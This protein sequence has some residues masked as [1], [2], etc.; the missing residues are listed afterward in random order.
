MLRISVARKRRPT[1]PLNPFYGYP[2]ELIAEWCGVSVGTAEH[3]KAGRRKPS[4]PVLRLFRL[5]RDRKVL[6]DE[7]SEYR[8]IDGRIFGPDGKSIRPVDIALSSLLWQALSERD[9]NGYY[10]LLE[11]AAHL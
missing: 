2:A 3:Y 9:P 5:Y 1:S 6:G 10:A 4:T 7:W 8:V 11:R